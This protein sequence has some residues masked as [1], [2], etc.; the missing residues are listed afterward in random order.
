MV[1]T[2]E[3]IVKVAGGSDVVLR[4]VKAYRALSFDDVDRILSKKPGIKTVVI[5]GINDKEKAELYVKHWVSR[6][7]H[8]I[9]RKELSEHG[10][11]VVQTLGELQEAISS[12]F[13]VDA[14]TVGLLQVHKENKPELPVDEHINTGAEI[15]TDIGIIE[16][17]EDSEVVS[18]IDD[19]DE[20]DEIE[21]PLSSGERETL[22]DNL[23]KKLNDLIAERDE[24]SRQKKSLEEQLRQALDRINVLLE[25][26]EVIEDERDNYKS[27]LDSINEDSDITVVIEPDN[28]RQLQE[29]VELKDAEISNL[30]SEIEALKNDIAQK[31]AEIEKLKSLIAQKDNE[32][33]QKD[34]EIEKLNSA[35]TQENAELDNSRK[36]VE[37]LKSELEL[38]IRQRDKVVSLLGCAI[39][40]YSN[41]EAT[42]KN[43]IEEKEKEISEL[44]TCV[45]NLEDTLASIN[46]DFQ[47]LQEKFDVEIKSYTEIITNK[48]LEISDITTK[49]GE[50]AEKCRELQGKVDEL[51]AK[52]KEKEVELAREVAKNANSDIAK[53]TDTIRILEETNKNTLKN[54]E[55]LTNEIDSLREKLKLAES[56]NTMLEETNKRLKSS[57]AAVTRGATGIGKLQLDCTYSGRAIIIP[58]FGSGSYGVTT[59]AVSIAHKLKGKVLFIDFDLVSPKADGWFGKSPLVKELQGIKDP[60]KKTGIGALIEK[61]SEY[62]IDNEKLLFQRAVELR[63]TTIDYFSGIYVYP[64]VTQLA[65]VDFS[66]FLSYAGS[67][68]NYIVV[69]LGRFGSSDIVNAV[70]KMFDSIAGRSVVVTL[71]DKFDVRTF[72]VKANEEKLSIK[73]FVWV[74]N[75][76]D[77]TKLDELINRSTGGAK[78]VIMPK[79]MQMY[80]SGKTFDK[81]G[82]LKDRLSEVIE[83]C[84]GEVN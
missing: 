18:I 32:I 42:Y 62:V 35:I 8:I 71:K 19:A 60:M 27:L 16:D 5:D 10:I 29:S 21:E 17:T 77:D 83:I 59:M 22:D 84:T 79:V 44:T 69:D 82:V 51:T 39:E 74:L 45:K 48:D 25:L 66:Q 1:G 75:F 70:I 36:A 13:G 80:G 49:Y 11:E 67:N 31:D 2:A 7:L 73:N 57:L 41:L 28:V 55:Y 14:R 24:L 46:A 33:A 23:A 43:D 12:R 15:P 50:V 53:L 30:K 47:Q 61:G 76:A 40:N 63:D 64:D 38:V 20:L 37:A 54:V 65:A 58:V 68:Y 78:V 72:A 81:F 4:N 56:T 6:G 34:S 3:V 9:S 52:L 26:K